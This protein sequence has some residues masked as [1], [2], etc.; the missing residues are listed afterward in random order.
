MKK[1]AKD[2]IYKYEPEADVLMWEV[3]TAKIDYAQESGNMVVHFDKKNQ[4]VLIEILEAKKF[5]QNTRNVFEKQL[6]P[7]GR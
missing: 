4:P 3:S 5:F 2:F 1:V 7:V 6:V